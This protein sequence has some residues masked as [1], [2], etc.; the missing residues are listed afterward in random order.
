MKTIHHVF[1]AQ[2]PRP[3]VYRALNTTE[4]L[5]NW[6]STVVEGD[7]RLGGHIH[8]TFVGDF[9]PDMEIIELNPDN[10]VRWRCVGGHQPWAD[11]TFRFELADHDSGSRVRFWQEYARELDDD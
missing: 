4:G 3:S 7:Y 11:G 9:N 2:V 10:L 5:G 1:D 6:W 8:F